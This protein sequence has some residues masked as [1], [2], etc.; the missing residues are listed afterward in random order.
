MFINITGKCDTP[1]IEVQSDDEI[2]QCALSYD[3]LGEERLEDGIA[4]FYNV[5]LFKFF[6]IKIH[7]QNTPQRWGVFMWLNDMVSPITLYQTDFTIDSGIEFEPE[8]KSQIHL[9]DQP[10]ALHDEW[11]CNIDLDQKLVVVG[12][13]E[14]DGRQAVLGIVSAD[15]VRIHSKVF[16]MFC[17]HV[18][19][20]ISFCDFIEIGDVSEDE[21]FVY[22]HCLTE[23]CNPTDA[24]GMYMA[25]AGDARSNVFFTDMDE[26]FYMNTQGK[27]Y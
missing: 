27:N 2:P 3:A 10:L 26:E 20:S 22:F 18:T 9:D 19:R 12:Y 13:E 4:G 11:K 1:Q 14:I 24:Y 25:V 6:N 15:L 21:A 23:C 16:F 5:D 7:Q 17:D 8:T